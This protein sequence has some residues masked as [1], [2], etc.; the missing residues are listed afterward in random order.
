MTFDLEFVLRNKG[1]SDL[2][3]PDVLL[4]YDVI[5]FTM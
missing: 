1:C 2:L 3:W 5:W 4:D